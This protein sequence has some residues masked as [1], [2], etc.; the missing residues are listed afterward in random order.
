MR[1]R[2][3]GAGASAVSG[4]PADTG[5]F[6]PGGVKVAFGPLGAAAQLPARLLEHL[7][8]RLQRGA[9]F[10]ALAG[11]V[12]AQLREFLGV[13]PGHRTAKK[14]R[15]FSGLAGGVNARGE[16]LGLKPE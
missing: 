9:Q 10:L 12:G 15:E 11:R 13:R 14:R 16:L 6:D 3:V 5:Q 4:V 7:G 8:A 2:P 1:R